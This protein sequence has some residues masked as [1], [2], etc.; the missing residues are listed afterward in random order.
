MEARGRTLPQ[1]F[2]QAAKGLTSLLVPRVPSGRSVS[3]RIEL[4]A[5]N[6][7]ELLVLFLNELIYLFA[8]H[9]EVFGSFRPRIQ[10]G[11]LV[12]R[13]KG[14]KLSPRHK[15]GREVK[16]CTRHLCEVRQGK[17]VTLRALIDL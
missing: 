11:K 2:S 14:V 1:A 6:N 7:E 13:M 4:F 15:R 3:R 8:V 17:E 16:S 10:N 5:E 12:A 9:K